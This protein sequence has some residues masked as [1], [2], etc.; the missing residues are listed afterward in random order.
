MEAERYVSEE[1]RL[2][3]VFDGAMTPLSAVL[4]SRGRAAVTIEIGG[5]AQKGGE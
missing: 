3:V 1:E 4:G 2:L 5:F